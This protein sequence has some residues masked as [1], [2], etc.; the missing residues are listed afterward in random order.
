MIALIVRI[1]ILSETFALLPNPKLSHVD[2]GSRKEIALEPPVANQPTPLPFQTAGQLPSSRWGDHECELPGG[3]LMRSGTGD[4]DWGVRL[5]DLPS[6]K[7]V[8]HFATG[9][10]FVFDCSPDGKTLA[11]FGHPARDGGHRATAVRPL[12]L[13]LSWGRRLITKPP[14]G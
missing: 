1:G 12:T 5:I 14:T 9:W 3:Q 2:F 13:R 7:T 8:R 4:L 10:V 11:T 6:G